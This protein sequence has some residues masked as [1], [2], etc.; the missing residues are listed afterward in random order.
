[1]RE[2]S[3]VL[4]ERCYGTVTSPPTPTSDS[5]GS[6]RRRIDCVGGDVGKII[7]QVQAGG[8]LWTSTLSLSQLCRCALLWLCCYPRGRLF[9]TLPSPPPNSPFWL[10]GLVW[11]I[12]LVISPKLSPSL[13]STVSRDWGLKVL[14]KLVVMFLLF[15]ALVGKQ[16]R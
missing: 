14:T 16:R 13:L 5:A 7:S 4:L 15:F 10:F 9:F 11:M 8:N 6:L 12:G 1:M 2:H 3:R